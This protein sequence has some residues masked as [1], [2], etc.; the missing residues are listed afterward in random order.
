MDNF[1]LVDNN[2]PVIGSR[3]IIVGKWFIIAVPRPEYVRLDGS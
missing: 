3:I 2:I 1:S